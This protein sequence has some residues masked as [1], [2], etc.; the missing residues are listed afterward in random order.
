M[1]KKY[2]EQ[3]VYEAGLD[4]I[5]R[6]YELYDDVVVWF[7]G[8]KDSTALLFMVKEVARELDKLP[9]KVIHIDEEAV[10]PPTVEYVERVSKDPE[11]D[12]NWYCLE[13][14]HRN[15]CSVQEPYWYCWDKEKKDLWIRDLP[16]QAITEH[17]A[18]IKGMTIPD[19][20]ARMHPAQ[21]IC[22]LMGIRTQE[23][24]RRYRIIAGKKQIKDSF[25]TIA[26]HRVQIEDKKHVYETQISGYPIYD[27]SSVD[28]WK[29]VK[30]NNLDYNK[31]YDIFNKTKLFN[32]L[33]IQRVCPPYGEEPLRGLWI[34]AECF[35][36][37]WHKMLY[38]V[39]GV[40][41]AWRYA[42]TE[43]YMH[44]KKPE[45]LTWRQYLKVLIESYEGKYNNEIKH[46]INSAIKEHYNKTTDKVPESEPHILSGCS[47]K[48]LCKLVGKGDFKGRKRQSMMGQGYNILQKEGI[49]LT[50]ARLNHGKK[51]TTN[52]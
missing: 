44:N 9:V 29:V 15:A 34:Y 46:Q 43:L 49:S 14:K 16:S 20:S 1:P 7:S 48:F 11:L 33:L 32:S 8:G 22:N 2:L 40:A 47:Y 39:K 41:T 36:E 37:M 3:N 24:M 21:S 52:K 6:I 5:R 42:N 35:P 25:I 23:S 38:R 18:F 4:R 17:P 30:E 45:N 26:K 31:T 50:S 12:F 27:M 28:V 10:H 19:F 13:V 51:Q